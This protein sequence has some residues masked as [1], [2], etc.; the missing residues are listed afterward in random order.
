MFSSTSIDNKLISICLN[1]QQ[2]THSL[3]VKFTKFECFEFDKPFADIPKCYLKAL[4]RNKVALNL[5][6]R[7]H[8]VPVPNV[9]VNAAYFVKGSTQNYRLFLYNNTVNFCKFLKNPN[10]Y[11]FWKIV[12]SIIKTASN[13]NHTCPYNHD[14]IVEHLVLDSDMF[15]VIPFP[16]GDYLVILKVAA[17]NHYKAEIRTYFSIKE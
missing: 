2:L 11:P 10:N 9:S 15:K 17:Y 4:A 14:I 1:I 3:T 12:Y 13:I 5:H 8:Q 7:L 16:T 6:V